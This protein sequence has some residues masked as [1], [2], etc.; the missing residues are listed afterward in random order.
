MFG[1]DIDGWDC[2]GL[3][4][5][6]YNVEYGIPI[7]SFLGAISTD[8]IETNQWLEVKEDPHERDVI[9]YQSGKNLHTGLLIDERRML[10]TIKGVGTCVEQIDSLLWKKRIEGVYRYFGL[11]SS[12]QAPTH[13]FCGRRREDSSTDTSSSPA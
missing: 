13:R 1:R 7:E 2:W 4:Y 12:V 8:K 11:S 6:I 9:L 3:I 5:Y 10:H